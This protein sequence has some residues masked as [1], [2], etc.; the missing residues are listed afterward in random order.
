M[1][2]L[3][4]PLLVSAGAIG[5]TPAAAGAGVYSTRAGVPAAQAGARAV[6]AG[7]SIVL[8]PLPISGLRVI[9]FPGTPDVSPQS[10]VIFSSLAPAEL[11]RVTAVGSRSGSHTGQERALPDNA[12]TAFQPRRP[13]VSGEHVLVTARLSSGRQID[14]TFTVATP[15]PRQPKDVM[16][17]Q[18][19]T[20]ARTATGYWFPQMH[21]RSAP[22]LHPPKVDV[23]SDP[24]THSG[25]IFLAP[26][27]NE[28]THGR[29]FHGGPMILNSRGQLVW[30]DPIGWSNNLQMQS[31][32]GHPVLTWLHRHTDLIYNSHYRK[33]AS[34]RAGNGYRTDMH[35]FQLTPRGTAYIAAN[36]AV[37]ANLSSVGG[38]SNG[39][40]EDD[41]VQELDIR[42]G[43]V[44]W[45]WHA[46][47]HVPLSASYSPPQG[48]YD[49]YFHLN[50]IQPLPDGNLLVS[51]RNTWAI[52]KISRRTGQ[53]LWKLGGKN[54]SF[55]IGPGANF[56]W[57]HDA[58]LRGHILTLFDDADQ[59]QEERQSSA[60]ILRLDTRKMTARLVDRYVH[61]PALL[62]PAQGSVELLPNGNIFVGWGIRPQFSEYAPG[63][64]QIF[65]G[66]FALGIS[67]YRAL[68]YTWIGHPL[69]PPALD[70]VRGTHRGATLYFSWNGA[71]QVAFWR[72]LGGSRPRSLTERAQVPD[73]RFETKFTLARAPRYVAVQA[74][75]ADGRVLGMSK[76]KAG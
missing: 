67:S 44:L 61:R 39:T 14:F 10:D 2:R 59:P 63:G 46:Y 15:P 21:F 35:E 56:E 9:P 45:E 64:R 40:V 52:Y 74:I 20:Q 69:S 18:Q 28:F 16:H 32:A 76:V 29:H 37:S 6:R 57:Q 12:G 62:S 4:A 11:R 75:Q 51:S 71:T 30:F 24:D 25:D 53:V 43:K 68:R 17:G 34:L 70:V 48:G 31:Y 23:S 66:S 19:Q 27:P 3:I 36:V 50:S 7:L 49:D 5:L 54:S 1:R 47:G 42:T 38:P 65:S 33:V 26:R 13:F 22:G 58:R 73:D 41:V 55:R 72:V 8:G 60:K